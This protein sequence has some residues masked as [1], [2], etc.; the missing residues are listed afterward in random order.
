MSQSKTPL[1][2]L[3]VGLKRIK[4]GWTKASFHRY[5]EKAFVCIEG[6]LTSGHPL[7]DT[8]CTP[9]QA[10][11]A[12]LINRAIAEYVMLPENKR[13]FADFIKVMEMRNK[14]N[15]VWSGQ[16]S[17][18]HIV[19]FNDFIGTRKKDVIAVFEMAILTAEIEEGVASVN[20][21]PTPAFEW[22]MPQ[23]GIVTVPDAVVN[24]S[25]EILI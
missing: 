3:R 13:R 12:T 20:K 10:R 23:P 7:S 22:T 25:S 11:A 4:R 16:E 18:N 2:V 1:K 21:T 5:V 19:S 9:A 6:A 24:P 17:A 8:M 15:D 14:M